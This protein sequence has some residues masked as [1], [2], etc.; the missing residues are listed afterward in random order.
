MAVLINVNHRYISNPHFLLKL[1]IYVLLYAK[2]MIILDACVNGCRGV[3]S[4][5]RVNK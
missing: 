1:Y 5:S 2:T 3:F 4:G